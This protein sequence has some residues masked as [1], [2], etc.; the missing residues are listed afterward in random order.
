MAFVSELGPRLGVGRTAEVF[1]LGGDRVVK[2]YYPDFAVSIAESEARTAELLGTAGLPVPGFFGF[3]RIDGRPGLVYERLNG[4][5]MS[6]AMRRQ[7]HKLPLFTRQFAALHR[8]LHQCE[9]IHLRP[10]RGYL[11]HRILNAPNL[12]E[13][14]RDQ[15]IDCLHRLPSGRQV[16]CHGDLHPANVMMTQRGPVAIDWTNACSGEAVAD[17]ARTLLLLTAGAPHKLGAWPWLMTA[18]AR[19][20]VSNRYQTLYFR[21][22]NSTRTQIRAWLPVLA[23]ARLAEGIESETERLLACVRTMTPR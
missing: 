1:A 20:F 18:L 7:P 3:V 12:S 15:L 14:T 22:R 6:E 9:R 21:D 17:V 2:L 5:T 11:A 23:A 13:A 10:Y 16:L 19:R 4:G 8:Q